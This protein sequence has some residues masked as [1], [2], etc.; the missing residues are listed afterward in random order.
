MSALE[1]NTV[2]AIL[3]EKVKSSAASHILGGLGILLVGLVLVA[4]SVVIV[5]VVLR[6]GVQPFISHPVWVRVLVSL[7]IVGLLFIGNTLGGQ[8]DLLEYSVPLGEGREDLKFQVPKGGLLS[9]VAETPYGVLKLITDVLCVGPR[10]V[11]S[12][13]RSFHK[14]ARLKKIDL[15]GCAAVITVLLSRE[16]RTPFTAI[17]ASIQGLN[18]AR[19]FPQMG[20][21]DGV[22]FLKKEPPGMSLTSA[23]REEFER[24][25]KGPK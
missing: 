1:F 25:A 21:I 23:F 7:L 10:T 2:R 11:A 16:S 15:D 14:A 20:D 6:Y 18:P 9:D 19:V 13:L 22:L 5:Y 12:S 8:E 24:R 3:K 4:V 17:L